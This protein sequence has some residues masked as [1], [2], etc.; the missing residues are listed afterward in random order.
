MRVVVIMSKVVL[1]VVGTWLLLFAMIAFP[2]LLPARWEYYLISP[3]SVGLWLIAM[4]VSPFFVCW[5]LR[6]WIAG[7]GS[8]VVP[9]RRQ[10]DGLR[11]D[12][13]GTVGHRG[14]ILADQGIPQSP[15]ASDGHPATHP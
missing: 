11:A 10:A 3:A 12:A 13:A 9:L 14:A 2:T 4:L 1:T 6:R 7:R 5:W 8:G 15:P